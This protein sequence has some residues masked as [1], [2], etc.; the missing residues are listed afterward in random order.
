MKEEIL[1]AMC[2]LDVVN[3][4][5]WRRLSEDDGELIEGMYLL[6]RVRRVLWKGL[7]P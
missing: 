2:A 7:R 1:A 3:G 6:E 5:A 4:A